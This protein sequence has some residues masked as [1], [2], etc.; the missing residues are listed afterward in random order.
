MTLLLDVGNTRVKA[1]VLDG[2]ALRHLGSVAYQ[3]GGVAGAVEALA[4]PS[5]NRAV[6]WSF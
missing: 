5:V 2:G 6:A 3:A 1:A 4:P